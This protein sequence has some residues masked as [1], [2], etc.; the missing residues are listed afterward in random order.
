VPVPPPLG[1]L[2]AAILGL[3]VRDVML[4]RDE[5]AGLMA[6]LLAT[7]SPPA[8]TT[9]LTDWARSHANE[10]GRHYASELA[11]RRNREAPHDTL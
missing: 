3:L 9:R 8:G 10:L 6:G 11:R 4:T 1:W 2:A 7:D 5:I